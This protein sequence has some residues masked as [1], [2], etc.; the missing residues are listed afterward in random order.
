MS[1]IFTM[2]SRLLKGCG[3]NFLHNWVYVSNDFAC[4]CKVR[5]LG[6]GRVRSFAG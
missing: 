4:V 2:I 5:C 3:N 1:S 6:C